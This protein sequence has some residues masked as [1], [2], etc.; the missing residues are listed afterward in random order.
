M[1]LKTD[2]DIVNFINK[3][4]TLDGATNYDGT[5]SAQVIFVLDNGKTLRFGITDDDV[6]DSPGLWFDQYEGLLIE[7]SE[8]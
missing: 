7:D 6:T 5:A 3:L 8:E 4:K 2:K 1:Y